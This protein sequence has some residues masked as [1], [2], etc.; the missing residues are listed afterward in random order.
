MKFYIKKKI[1]S[2]DEQFIVKDDNNNIVYIITNIAQFSGIKTIITDMNENEV[3]HIEKKHTFLPSYNYYMNDTLVLNM[4]LKPKFMKSYY[5][6]S[7]GYRV[8]GDSKGFNYVLFDEKN[9]EIAMIKRSVLDNNYELEVFD[10]TRKE[11]VIAVLEKVA[12]PSV[13]DNSTN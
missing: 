7:N 8:E 10:E 12:I 5:I 13:Y 2:L 6:L 4:K 11:I 1:P 9:Q 3:V